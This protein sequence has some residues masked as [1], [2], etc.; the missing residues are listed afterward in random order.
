MTFSQGKPFFHFNKKMSREL[1][2]FTVQNL[3]S[4]TSNLGTNVPTVTVSGTGLVNVSSVNVISKNCHV[5]NSIYF[6]Q[7]VV[8][9]TPVASAT[10]S[11]FQVT[12][13]DRTST[14][15][16][17][18]DIYGTCQGYTTT[19]GIN[20]LT[21]TGIWASTSSNRMVV[22]FTSN[23]TNLHTLQVTASYIAN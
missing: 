3:T 20:L 15:T 22:Q 1:V 11:Q 21:G 18:L 5:N 7:F 12:V 14:N 13:Q 8:Q 6:L 17:E 16:S 19:G 9:A 10:V 23:S 4:L 2:P